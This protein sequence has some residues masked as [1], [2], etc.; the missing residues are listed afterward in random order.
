MGKKIGRSLVAR[1]LGASALLGISLF[2]TIS[3]A[4]LTCT[5]RRHKTWLDEWPSLA[6]MWFRVKNNIDLK[7]FMPLLGQDFV[8]MHATPKEGVSHNVWW[9]A[10][11]RALV[12]GLNCHFVAAATA[13]FTVALRTPFW[14]QASDLSLSRL[15][16]V[17]CSC[18]FVKRGE[19]HPHLLFLCHVLAVVSHLAFKPA[20]VEILSKTLGVEDGREPLVRSQLWIRLHS[21]IWS[22]S[23]NSERRRTP[24]PRTTQKASRRRSISQRICVEASTCV[25]SATELSQ[26]VAQVAQAVRKTTASQRVRVCDDLDPMDRLEVEP[27]DADQLDFWRA[28]YAKLKG[29]SPREGL[30][31]AM[32]QLAT[33]H[34]RVVTLCHE[35]TSRGLRPAHPEWATRAEGA[36]L[37]SSSQTCRRLGHP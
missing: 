7:N 8:G 29:G 15:L 20:D 24:L 3:S 31:C 14:V 35:L 1:S 18:N 30:A 32:E 33:M 6:P 19:C 25:S 37:Q 2:S 11:R 16:F 5:R 27:P 21:R 34:A 36:L 28:N 23:S 9:E 13:Q 26:A 12:C 22:W 17:V 4:L 10:G